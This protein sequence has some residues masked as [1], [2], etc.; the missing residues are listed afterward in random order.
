MWCIAWSDS[1]SLDAYLLWRKIKTRAIQG[2][3]H[4]MNKSFQARS[5]PFMRLLNR[6]FRL[7]ERM[8][9]LQNRSAV[10]HSDYTSL[11]TVSD[12]LPHALLG[13]F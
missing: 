10:S 13:T 3:I 8:K 7:P 5:D 1:L 12:E 4:T 6:S 2:F 9:E 11:A